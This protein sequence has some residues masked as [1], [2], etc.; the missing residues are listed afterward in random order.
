[1]VEIK[2]MGC[3]GGR[4]VRVIQRRELGHRAVSVASVNFLCR[5]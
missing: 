1:M 3:D 2:K 4:N 5:Y